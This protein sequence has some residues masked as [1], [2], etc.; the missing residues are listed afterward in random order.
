MTYRKEIS[1]IKI[2]PTAK[3]QCFCSFVSLS[4]ISEISIDMIFLE[5][6]KPI[7]SPNPSTTVLR[8]IYSL[9]YP[10]TSKLQFSKFCFYSIFKTKHVLHQNSITIL[11]EMW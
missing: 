7:L 11:N 1:F 3:P 2:I 6:L 5:S 4:D 10:L 9:S 8:G